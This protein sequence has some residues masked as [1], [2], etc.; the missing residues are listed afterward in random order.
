MGGFTADII[1]SAASCA[2]RH[3]R[4]RIIGDFQHAQLRRATKG[5]GNSKPYEDNS[6]RCGIKIGQ[7]QQDAYG[8][9]ELVFPKS[10]IG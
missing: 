9:S 7:T 4:T 1:V 3:F 6:Q 2:A 8:D 5:E 10:K